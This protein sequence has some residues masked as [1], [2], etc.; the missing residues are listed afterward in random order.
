VQVDE[1]AKVQQREPV[2]LGYY[3]RGATPFFA[4]AA[5]ARASFCL[6]VPRS[7]DE[8]GTSPA[9]LIVLVH[10]TERGA[11]RY[12]DEFAGF[13]EETGAIVLAPLFPVGLD[14]PLGYD[15]YKFLEHAGVRYDLLLLAMVDQIAERYRLRRDALLLHGFSG[16]GH[17]AHRFAYLHGK[18]LRAV[19]IGAPG[20]VTLLDPALPWWAGTDGMAAKFG[21]PLDLDALRGVQVQMVVGE[22]DTE[23]WEI[24]VPPDSPLFLPG[25]NDAGVTRIDRLRSLAAS[26][27]KQGVRVRF[28]LIPG[29]AHEGWQP[30]LLDRVRDFFRAALV[31]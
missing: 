13:A 8:A 28:D 7:Y 19:S 9:D 14:R 24:T 20:V 26:F 18:R 1:G 2:R 25:I 11:A 30:A 27:S 5:D 15:N 3:E 17:F 31:S 29:V 23:T 22:A 12:R 21:L 6:Y 4:C 16:G 10:G